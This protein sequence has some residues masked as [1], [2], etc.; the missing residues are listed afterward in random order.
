MELDIQ[1]DFRLE[2]FGCFQTIDQHLQRI[3]PVRMVRAVLD[4][5]G[6]DPGFDDDARVDQFLRIDLVKRRM[7]S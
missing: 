7:E 4:Y 2:V 1:I 5:V 6:D 3:D